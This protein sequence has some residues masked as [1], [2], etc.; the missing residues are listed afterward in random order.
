MGKACAAARRSGCGNPGYRPAKKLFLELFS[1]NALLSVAVLWNKLDVAFLCRPSAKVFDL[2]CKRVLNQVLFW[3][4]Q[5]TVWWVDLAPPHFCRYVHITLGVLQTCALIG[6]IF[7]TVEN[8]FAKCGTTET[9]NEALVTVG[10]RD[11]NWICAGEE[12][13]IAGWSSHASCWHVLLHKTANPITGSWLSVYM[14]GQP[15]CMATT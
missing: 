15:R 2:R 5:K 10:A 8:P 4:L 14:D 7:A 1:E 3:I 9:F 6:D 11:S 12:H 13:R